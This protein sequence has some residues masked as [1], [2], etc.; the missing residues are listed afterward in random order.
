MRSTASRS[1]GPQSQRAEPKTSP[2]RHSECI[3]T[4]GTPAGAGSPRTR[5]R[6]SRPSVRPWKVTASAV[7]AYPSAK[8]SGMRT[9]VRSVARA[10]SR[11]TGDTPWIVV[12]MGAPRPDRSNLNK[13]V[14]RVIPMAS[15]TWLTDEE[16]RA[17]Q[18]FLAAVSL[19]DRRLDQ[20][21]KEDAG[22]SHLQYEI[23]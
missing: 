3:R 15:T 11:A 2:V 18:A 7:T 19:I 1:W 9:R 4:S 14:A 6:C 5:A 10:V 13:A 12:L 17:W 22:V 8:R 16:M 23:L 20:Q 21:L